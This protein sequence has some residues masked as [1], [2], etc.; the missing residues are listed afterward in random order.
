MYQISKLSREINLEKFEKIK[1]R[2]IIDNN[3]PSKIPKPISSA[4]KR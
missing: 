2:I 4:N 3:F 1:N